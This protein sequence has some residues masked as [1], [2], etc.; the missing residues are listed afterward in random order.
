MQLSDEITIHNSPPCA[1]NTTTRPFG[2]TNASRSQVAD[3]LHRR[4]SEVLLLLRVL[5]SADRCR[6]MRRRR[7]LH[8]AY[9][10]NVIVAGCP[11]TGIAFGEIECRW[12]GSA[13][14]G[15]VRSEAE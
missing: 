2:Y 13:G 15:V 6:D 12:G 11:R 8:G 14:C 4:K 9:M 5:R 1:T 10:L 7:W 3:H